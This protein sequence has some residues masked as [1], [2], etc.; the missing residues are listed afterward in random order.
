MTK[1]TKHPIGFVVNTHPL[2]GGSNATLNPKRRRKAVA[3]RPPTEWR[4]RCP[5]CGV[6]SEWQPTELA[7]QTWAAGHRC[8]S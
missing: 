6:R 4:V 2:I 7:A 3:K 5:G 1:P 8:A